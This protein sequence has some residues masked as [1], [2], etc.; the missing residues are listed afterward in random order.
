MLRGSLPTFLCHMLE[1]LFKKLPVFKFE[2]FVS[3]SYVGVKNCED[4]H[5]ITSHHGEIVDS[6]GWERCAPFCI[7]LNN[8]PNAHKSG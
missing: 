2:R 6:S 5:M 8:D 4:G 1:V 3:V 7:C